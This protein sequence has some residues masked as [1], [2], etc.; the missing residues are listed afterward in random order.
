MT[1]PST[2]APG[3]YA[4]PVEP[5]RLA[6]W[7]GERWTGARR[8]RPTWTDRQGGRV[9]RGRLPVPGHGRRQWLVIGIAVAIVVGLAVAA[10]PRHRDDGPRVLTDAGFIAAANQRCEATINDIRPPLSPDGKSPTNAEK[11]DAADRAADGLGHLADELRHL[12]VA[13]TDEPHVTGWLAVWEQYV[14]VGHRTA[15]ALRS[16]HPND[17]LAVGRQGDTFQQQADRFARANGLS[18]CQ[19]F[20]VPNGSGSDPFS[21][22]Q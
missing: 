17:A 8:P 20:I 22:G 1:E 19:F 12:P 14:A 13:S 15:A 7:D 5:D 11:A 18:R 6:Y 21:G 9:G 16:D 10:L 4:D 3:W 2:H